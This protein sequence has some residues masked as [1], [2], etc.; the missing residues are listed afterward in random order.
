M[1]RD[2]LEQIKQGNNH[3]TEETANNYYV[4]LMSASKDK[5]ITSDE[6]IA[7]SEAWHNNDYEKILWVFNNFKDTMPR[8]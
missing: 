3:Y 5:L 1:K 4:L 7:Y 2:I 6:Y 8:I